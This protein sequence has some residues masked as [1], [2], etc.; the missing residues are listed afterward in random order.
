M[1]VVLGSKELRDLLFDYIYDSEM[2]YLGEKLGCFDH[3]AI[4]YSYSLSGYCYMNIM[5]TAEAVGGIEESRRAFGASSRVEKLLNHCLNLY[6][7]NLF[8]YYAEKLVEA[9]HEDEMMAS[10]NYLSDMASAI[11]WGDIEEFEKLGGAD[12]FDTFVENGYLDDYM[13]QRDKVFK[14]SKVA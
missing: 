3:G 8:E 5:N 2:D 9:Y 1:S 14:Y 4:D 13:V 11:H 10:I 7:S 12:F 6:G